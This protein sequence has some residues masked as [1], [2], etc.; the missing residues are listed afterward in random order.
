M[1]ENESRKKARAGV[2]WRLFADTKPA[3][4]CSQQIVGRK[5][6]GNAIQ[7]LLRQ[8][9]LFGEQVERLIVLRCQ[10]GGVMQMQAGGFQGDQVPFARQV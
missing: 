9:Q 7:P 8:T 6:A 2:S 10:F 5:F 4:N 3:K 1:R